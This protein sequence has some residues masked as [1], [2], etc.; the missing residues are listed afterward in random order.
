M[1]NWHWCWIFGVFQIFPLQKLGRMGW[2]SSN[3]QLIS[4]SKNILQVDSGLVWVAWTSLLA[5]FQPRVSQAVAHTS[6]LGWGA[7]SCWC[8]KY[9]ASTSRG[10]WGLGRRWTLARCEVLL[11]GTCGRLVWK[12]SGKVTWQWKMDLLKMYSL[13]RMGIF[14]CHVSLLEG[15]SC[16]FYVQIHRFRGVCQQLI[17]QRSVLEMFIIYQLIYNMKYYR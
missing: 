17:G 5:W 2:S 4:F 10:Y 12:H 15:S 7:K 3:H 1:K 8:E 6:A 16:M 13:L 11:M 14:H 9:P